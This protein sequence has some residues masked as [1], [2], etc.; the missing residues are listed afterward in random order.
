MLPEQCVR[1]REGGVLSHI[2]ILAI[3][4]MLLSREAHKWC[5]REIRWNG[6]W[7]R[8]SDSNSCFLGA[9]MCDAGMLGEERK[10]TLKQQKVQSFNFMV[11]SSLNQLQLGFVS[12]SD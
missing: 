9:T 3:Q 2:F 1:V 6:L 8:I 4:L 5:Q 12:F 10:S 7:D 11:S